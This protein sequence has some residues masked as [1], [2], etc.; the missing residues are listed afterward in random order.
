MSWRKG[1]LEET[2]WGMN[3]VPPCKYDLRLAGWRRCR[4]LFALPPP[5]FPL[6]FPLCRYAGTR[7]ALMQQTCFRPELITTSLRS[8]AAIPYP[9]HIHCQ[10]ARSSAVPDEARCCLVEEC[11][12]VLP[13]PAP[14]LT[15]LQYLL[16]VLTVLT[17]AAMLA[18]L[19]KS[20]RGTPVKYV[21][22]YCRE[23]RRN[24][25]KEKEKEKEG[26][27]RQSIHTVCTF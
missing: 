16:T 1:V 15:Y 26:K 25:G 20:M 12:F 11:F 3:A 14:L 18:R 9:F 27:G 10:F 4:Y 21:S 19:E 5:V 22:T 8:L 23:E 7:L 2:G 13:G 6:L 17:V 24:E